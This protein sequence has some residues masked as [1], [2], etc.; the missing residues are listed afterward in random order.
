MNVAQCSSRL[1][2]SCHMASNIS[3][4]LVILKSASELQG[5]CQEHDNWKANDAL[6]TAPLETFQ[7]YMIV[8]WT[9]AFKSSNSAL[10]HVDDIPLRPILNDSSFDAVRLADLPLRVDNVTLRVHFA[11]T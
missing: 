5:I 4:L 10:Y 8:L 9:L 2:F 7:L 3:N 6:A 11:I 1:V